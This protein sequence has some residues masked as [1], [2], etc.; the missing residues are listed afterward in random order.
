MKQNVLPG[1]NGKQLYHSDQPFLF[2][3]GESIPEL[4][5][6]FETFGQL[7]AQKDNAILINHALSTNSH[8]CESASN[9][10]P[11]W[12]N[13]MVG[14][15]KPINTEEY[16]VICINNLGSCFGSSGPTSINPQTQRAYRTTFP[17][18]SIQDMARSQKMLLDFLGIKQVCAVIGPS[19]GAMCSLSFVVYFPEYARKFISI[20]SCYRSYPTT[21]A[22]RQIQR[23]IIRLDP[24]WK[25]GA[26]TN[27]NFTGFAL[28]RKLGQLSY[29]D[30]IQFDSHFK[31]QIENAAEK[32]GLESYLQYNAEKFTT[33][34]DAN[35][36][37]NLTQAMD[38]F[39]ICTEFNS[40]SEALS[41]IKAETLIISE[42]SDKLFFPYQQQAL[43]EIL[44][45]AGVNSQY[46]LHQ[47]DYGHDAFL[48][49]TKSFGRYIADFI[50][51]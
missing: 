49:E 28:A 2:I 51:A 50:N 13:S 47:S 20:S 26:Y 25:Q 8:V 46:I 5:L 34:F 11:G 36:Y 10:T 17:Q 3:S 1:D 38:D 42:S 43:H 35:S 32:Q 48:L 6:A 31:D 29:R 22:I 37:L 33:R 23:D 4:T 45:D 21:K 7:T 9:P 30:S 12:W 18:V 39:D 40:L 15:N 27:S 16:Y 44:V 24:N 41:R 19:M 14:P